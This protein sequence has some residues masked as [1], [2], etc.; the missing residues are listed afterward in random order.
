MRLSDIVYR[1]FA[2][3]P[4]SE[5]D[6][7]PWNDPEFSKHMLREHL[8][9]DHDAASRR[10]AKIDAHVEWIH[11]HLLEGRPARVLDL[12]CGPGLYSAR[13]ARLGHTCVGIDYSP[14]SIDYAIR[15]A[16]AERL[17]CRFMHKD[18]RVAEYGAGYSLAML[19]Y[20]ELN[21]FSRQDARLILRR[22]ADALVPGGMLLLEPHNEAWML[23]AGQAGSSW[24]SSEGGL[25][26]EVPHLVLTEN[27]WDDA[28]RILTIRHYLI[29]AHDATVTRY[30]QSMQTYSIDEYRD[31]LSECGFGD[32]RCYSSLMGKDD[33]RRALSWCWSRTR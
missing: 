17:A 7:I 6:N 8:S 4:W 9:Q 5:G 16:E 13:L 22:A 30:A 29:T 19:L 3:E 33:P 32:V 2:P 26:A 24:Y 12:G 14:A 25:F 21:V 31:L 15:Q 27:I 1:D 20:G 11:T 18:I 23:Q 28:R 10:A